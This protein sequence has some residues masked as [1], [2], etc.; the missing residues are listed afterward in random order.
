MRDEAPIR[1]GSQEICAIIGACSQAGVAV[2]KFG[3]LFVRFDQKVV[4]KD[5]KLVDRD[6]NA[7]PAPLDAAPE[8]EI[9]E[10]HSKI[11]AEALEEERREVEQLRLEM[12]ELED[13]AAL[14]DKIRR[15]E[16]AING[17]EDTEEA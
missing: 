2:L 8:A 16:I 10:N 4:Q 5:S 11:E 15:G 1:L 6:P 13:P 9:S 3:D 7:D 17:D 12:L 14:L